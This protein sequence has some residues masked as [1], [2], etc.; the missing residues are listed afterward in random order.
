MEAPLKKAEL[1]QRAGLTDHA[2]GI[3]FVLA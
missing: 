3:H 2:D 1:I